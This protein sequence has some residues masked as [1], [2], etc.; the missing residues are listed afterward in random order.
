VGTI[1]PAWRVIIERIGEAMDA[2]VDLRRGGVFSNPALRA[3]TGPAAWCSSPFAWRGAFD[4]L[5]FTRAR[6]RHP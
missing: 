2:G 3:V 5:L 1:I 6:Q 4:N